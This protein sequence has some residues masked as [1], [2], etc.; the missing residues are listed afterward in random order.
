MNCPKC[1]GQMWDNTQNKRNPKAPDFKCK[2]KKCID[3]ETGYGTAI[4]LP[5][6]GK[7]PK[8][9][10]PEFPPTNPP[11]NSYQKNDARI[12][13]LAIVKSMI[14]VDAYKVGTLE[15]EDLKEK[16][17]ADVVFFENRFRDA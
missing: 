5:K 17:Y 9:L 12:S 11:K 16:I 10:K 4:W 1:N 8:P 3:P 14:E 2:D 15:H 6:G 7:A 13:A